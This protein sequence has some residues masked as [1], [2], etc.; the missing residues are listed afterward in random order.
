MG[1]R[2][3][4]DVVTVELAAA[5]FAKLMV[6]LG[7]A[8]ALGHP[9]WTKEERRTRQDEILR[10]VNLLNEGNEHWRPYGRPEKLVE[11]NA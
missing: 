5:D 9:E 1:Y 2:R 3:V 11:R 7:E 4:E 10:L 6:L 8:L